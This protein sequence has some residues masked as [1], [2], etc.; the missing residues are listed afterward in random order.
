[1]SDNKEKIRQRY[2]QKN[3]NIVII[4]PASSEEENGIPRKLR[5]CAYCRV[6]T[7]DEAQTSSYELQYQYYEEFIKDRK[8]WDFVGIYADEGISGTSLEKRDDFNRMI[9]DCKSGKIDLIVTKDMSRFSRN[10]LDCITVLRALNALE[11]KVG[12][13]FEREHINTLDEYNELFITMSSMNAQHESKR[14]SEAMLWSLERRFQRGIFLR[15]TETLL[16]YQKVEEKMAIEPEGAKTVRLIF[17]M[18]LSGYSCTRIAYEMTA[19]Q[20]PTGKGNL[21][22]SPGSVLNILRN[23]RYCGDIIAQKTYTKDFFTHKSAQNLGQKP[24]YYAADDHEPIIS[25]EE[26]IQ[27]LLLLSSNHNSNPINT[28]YTLA[29]VKNGLLKGFI[30]INRAFGGYDA[31][32]YV[33][34]TLNATKKEKRETAKMVDFPGLQVARIQEFGHAQ[35]AGLIISERAMSFNRECVNKMQDSEYVE[36][37]LHPI[38]KLLV[39]RPS[40]KKNLNAIKWKKVKNGKIQPNTVFCSAFAKII[41]TLMNWTPIQRFKFL[42]ICQTRGNESI[43]FFDLKEAEHRISFE[44]PVEVPKSE[45]TTRRR[46]KTLH[47]VEWRDSFGPSLPQHAASCRWHRAELFGE[48][49]ISAPALS[50]AGFKNA[51]SL[52]E[53]EIRARITNLK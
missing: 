22:W 36:I 27:T 32:H 20:R 33:Q 30:P 35:L 26:Y 15:P 8:D 37:L 4:P 39:V 28:D 46:M 41:Y 43:L 2:A 6:S 44:E 38:E 52:S 23:E 53:K 25:R 19:L 7:E 24:V 18:F 50:V 17:D 21:F 34:A 16:G 10:V 14:K 12:V 42:A 45:N 11:P 48:W 1:M 49:N 31:E 13:F 40:T 5:A 47:P 9:A 51:R 29:V 3:E